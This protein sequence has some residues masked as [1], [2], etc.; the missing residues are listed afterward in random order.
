MEPE[1]IV[2]APVTIGPEIQ[3][4]VVKPTFTFFSLPERPMVPQEATAAASRPESPDLAGMEKRIIAAVTCR[5]QQEAKTGKRR[6]EH[7]SAVHLRSPPNAGGGPTAIGP[8]PARRHGTPT[9]RQTP[10]AGLSTLVK[11]P[12]SSR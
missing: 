2:S 10:A 9:S 7:Q 11:K 3:V 8:S 1:I 5:K 4:V 12:R 6:T